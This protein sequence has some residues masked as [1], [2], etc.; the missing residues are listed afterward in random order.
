MKEFKKKF[1]EAYLILRNEGRDIVNLFRMLLSSG[2]P[3]IS[4]KS[5]KLLDITLC[6]S[7]S[8]Q[9]AVKSIQDAI[10]YVMKK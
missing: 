5:I 1:K 7:K 9:E 10:N 3:E 6:L 8:E 4:K 2:F